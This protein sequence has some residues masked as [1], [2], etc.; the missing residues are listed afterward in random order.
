M[1]TSHCTEVHVQTRDSLAKAASE[2]PSCSGPPMEMTETDRAFKV[3]AEIPGVDPHQVD[4]RFEDGVLRIAGVER[5][6]R[7]EDERSCL[8]SE[9]SY[10]A[11]DLIVRL[12]A[13]ANPR[14][15]KQKLEN[16]VLTIT[17][18]KISL[19]E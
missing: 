7:E 15:M 4:L 9:R 6:D 19:R 18:P 12:P 14:K 10:G 16:G 11:F 5:L 2:M 1:I 13:S 17:I 3:T 8:V